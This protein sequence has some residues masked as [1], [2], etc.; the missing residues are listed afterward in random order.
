MAEIKLT[1][2]QQAVVDDR[3]GALLVSAAAGSGKTKVLVDRLLARIC[4]NNNPCDLDSFLII[5]YTKAAASE[6]RL[7]ITQALSKKIA[8]NPT[9]Q[10]LQRQMHRIYLAE[11]S[12]VHAFCSNLLRTYAHLLDIPADFRVT[13]EAESK[14]LQERI[15]RDLIDQNYD[16]PSADFVSMVE[17]FG[18]GRDDRR[19]PEAVKLAHKQ[20]RCRPDMDEWLQSMLE[21]L[22]ISRYDDVLET[23]W[24][25][26]IFREFQRFL[27]RQI[28]NMRAGLQEMEAYPNINKGLSKFFPSLS[29][30]LLAYAIN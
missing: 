12:T 30:K 23:P 18:Y 7:K 11:I 13:E 28:S 2:S 10:H 4:D 6:L 8:A 27:D 3:G 19:L 15:L 20:L 29:S 24:G 22:D 21:A 26:Y 9:N 1:A 17:A 14:L 25:S 5:T 16:M